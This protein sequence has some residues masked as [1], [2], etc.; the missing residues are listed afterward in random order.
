MSLSSKEVEEKQAVRGLY[1]LWQI[2]DAGSNECLAVMGPLYLDDP[3]YK[4][5]AR[6]LYDDA[7]SFNLD[8]VP[9]KAR[10]CLRSA[11][12]ISPP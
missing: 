12:L 10:Y 1:R 4:G 5:E 6:K 2:Y 8:G 9:R 7:H 11:M 3:K